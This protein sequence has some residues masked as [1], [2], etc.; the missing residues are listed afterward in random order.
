[1]KKI[2]W[3]SPTL[4]LGYDWSDYWDVAGLG[5]IMAFDN[6]YVSEELPAGQVWHHGAMLVVRLLWLTL[7]ITITSPIGL[8][9]PY[10]DETEA[11]MEAVEKVKSEMRIK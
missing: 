9:Y 11:T 3:H 2:F 4:R 8:L 1:M 7:R 10:V 5:V 6:G